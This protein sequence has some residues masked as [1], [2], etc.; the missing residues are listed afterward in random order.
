MKAVIIGMGEVGKYLAAVLAGEHHDV[1][2]VDAHADSL[3]RAEET[4]DVLALRGHG[5][6]MRVLREAGAGSADLVAAVTDR[7]EVNL[8]AALM[9]KELGAHKVIA[10]VVEAAYLDDEDRGYYHGLLGI[11]LVVSV[12]VLVANEIYKLVQSVGAVAVENFADNRVEMVQIPVREEARAVGALLRD[13]PLPSECIVAALKRGDEVLIPGGADAV[14]AGDEVFLIG[15]VEQIQRVE[16]LF[17]KTRERG[18]RKVVIVGGGD[19]GFAVARLLERDRLDVT[20]IERD[21]A[22]AEE[23][24]RHLN[25]TVL[26]AGDGTDLAL[27]REERVGACDVFV[28]TSGDDEVNLM[29][30][31]LAKN[32][33]AAKTITLV[34]RP[35]YVPTYELLGLDATVSPRLFAAGQILKYAR[36]GEVV[37]VSLLEGGRAEILEIVP[38]AGSAVVGKRLMDL[39]F[40]RGAVIAVVASPGRGVFVP[41]GRDALQAGDRVVVFTLPEVRPAVERFFRKRLFSLGRGGEASPG[42]GPEAAA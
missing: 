20:L 32:L 42:A 16:G 3:A 38:E 25:R 6:S 4:L 28:A 21:A 22:R 5:A 18:V 39:N 36:Q 33:G 2:I 7:D 17:G 29:S 1:T 9:A 35:D 27:L 8:L 37:A 14:L 12:Q 31:L 19:V 34:N 41:R 40:P 30:S 11:D 23:L 10:R 26:L 15:A 13:L 24:A